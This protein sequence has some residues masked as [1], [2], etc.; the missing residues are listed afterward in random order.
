MEKKYSF[1]SIQ[2]KLARAQSSSSFPSSSSTV[3]RARTSPRTTHTT[4]RAQDAHTPSHTRH[5]IA[6]ACNHPRPRR[7]PL[8]RRRRRPLR[9]RRRRRPWPHPRSR[10]R[11]ARA[12][13]RGALDRLSENPKV[14]ACRARH[15]G[16]GR[17][18][19]ASQ[20][21]ASSAGSTP[22]RLA[23]KCERHAL[24]HGVGLRPGAA[25]TFLRARNDEG[26]AAERV[27]R[28]AEVEA[29]P[30]HDRERAWR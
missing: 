15:A 28:D 4:S 25:V 16:K 21:A 14:E 17:G 12:I 30:A 13:A 27:E 20:A 26:E 29:A 23:Q 9:R 1:S 11:D 19:K 22:G 18:N 2:Q 8:R 5:L 3:I 24:V 10:P 7:R 6:R